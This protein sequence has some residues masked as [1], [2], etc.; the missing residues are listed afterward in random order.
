MKHDKRTN[1]GF[2][3]PNGNYGTIEAYVWGCQYGPNGKKRKK[4]PHFSNPNVCY[5]DV[6]TGDA[7]NNNAAYITTN[8]FKSRDLGTNCLDGKPDENWKFGKY[9]N[10]GQMSYEP[11]I[12]YS[13]G[14]I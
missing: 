3:P 9:C 2:C 12:N 7:N 10:K 1:W 8:R 6:A 14:I 11:A 4:A 13:E 5:E